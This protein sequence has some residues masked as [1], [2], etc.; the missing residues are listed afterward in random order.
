MWQNRIVGAGTENPK[1][2]TPNPKNWRK[3]PKNQ[4]QA[5]EGALEEIGWLQ[6]IIINQ[7]TGRLI[8]GHLRV[9][10]AIRNKEKS[11]PVKYVDLSEEEEEKAL[12][13]LDPITSMAEADK[14]ILNS[15]I[16]SCKTDNEKIKALLQEIAEKEKLSFGKRQIEEDDYELPV[17]IET[18]IKRGDILQLGR[19]RIMCGDS[20]SIEDV[21]Q[22]I[23]EDKISMVFTDPP[24]DLPTNQ[25]EIIFKIA[26]KFSNLQFWMGSDKQQ[27]Y[28]C[29]CFF[30]KFT[31]FFIHD[32]KIGTL[33][34]NSQPMQRHNLI[35]KFGNRK[36]NN[37]K[38]AFST[39]IEVATM[40]NNSDEHKRFKMGKRIQLPLA[41]IEH[42]SNKNDIILDLFGGAGST[43]LACEQSNRQARIM[44]LSPGYCQIIKDKYEKFIGAA[45]V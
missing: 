28:L 44:E 22:L 32:Y 43:L 2:L 1:K 21:E 37:L 41:F 11:V 39:I 6:D 19:H 27:I 13:T 4:A 7:R 18:D 9:E 36:T 35:S 30:N 26:D 8:D 20:T 5:L 24:Y 45:S 10:L 42:Y 12:I 31:H 16:E 17:E 14:D 34:S 33:I 38:D 23:A 3:H 15:L 25:L 40:R 29:N